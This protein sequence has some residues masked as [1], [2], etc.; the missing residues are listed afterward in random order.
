MKISKFRIIL[1]LLLIIFFGLL[2]LFNFNKIYEGSTPINPSTN[3]SIYDSSKKT[4]DFAL[5][6]SYNT[7]TVTTFDTTKNGPPKTAANS[8]YI[9]KIYF[10]TPKGNTKNITKFNLPIAFINH[11]LPAEYNL[12]FNNSTSS[13]NNFNG[14]ISPESSQASMYIEKLNTKDSSANFIFSTEI[15]YA[16]KSGSSLKTIKETGINKWELAKKNPNYT[17]NTGPPNNNNR[18]RNVVMVPR[19]LDKPTKQEYKNIST[20]NNNAII[21]FVVN[22]GS[23]GNVPNM[24][25]PNSSDK[26][27]DIGSINLVNVYVKFK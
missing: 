22:Y 18:N 5:D 20:P 16:T 27:E 25:T 8:E 26:N 9:I 11:N 24:I 23:Y 2:I 3:A 17:M 7:T 15:Y 21:S 6:P 14:I 10:F 19:N 1:I 13:T 12:Y 4:L